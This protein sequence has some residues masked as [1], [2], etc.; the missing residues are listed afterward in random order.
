LMEDHLRKKHRTPALRL[1]DAEIKPDI[2]LREEHK[3][4][5]AALQAL[6]TDVNLAPRL[7]EL[8]VGKL[9]ECADD[10]ALPLLTRLAVGADL[11][12]AR[13]AKSAIGGI[14]RVRKM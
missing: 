8:A 14:E 11:N 7:R 5:S 1:R 12:V 6:L 9:G 10:M 13:A 3:R 2:T 4:K